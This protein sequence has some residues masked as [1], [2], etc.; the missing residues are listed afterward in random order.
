MEQKG[1]IVR[2][3]EVEGQ[4]LSPYFLVR[5]PDGKD[6]FILNLKILNQFMVKNHFKLE[7]LSTVEQ[8]LCQNDFVASI[9]MKDAYLLIP[10]H[11]ESRKFVRFKFKNQIFEFVSLAFGLSPAPHTY[12]KL[13]KVPISYLRSLGFTNVYYL[14]D[15]LA[16]ERTKEK[17]VENIMTAV[18][19]LQS[20]GFIIN[21]KKSH[22]NPTQSTIFLGIE[23]D[24]KNYCFKLPTEK[25]EHLISLVKH[26]LT[27][28]RCTIRT[29][30]F[31]IGKLISCCTAIEYAYLYTKRMEKDKIFHLMINNN[32]YEANMPISKVVREDLEWW[33]KNLESRVRYIKDY[34]F[35]KTIYTDAS[36]TGWGAT[37]GVRKIHGFWS[38]KEKQAHINFLEL[39]T[40]K[41]ALSELIKNAK[42]IKVLLRIDN[43]TAIFYV[44]KMGGVRVDR[45][46]NLAREIWQWAENREIRL[47]ASYISSKENCIADELSRISQIDIEWELND[48]CFKVLLEKW[49]EPEIDLFASQENKKCRQFVSWKPQQGALCIDA[50]TISW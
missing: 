37:D 19:L 50:F 3:S 26:F 27:L 38:E 16:I 23:I 21:Y 35:D 34:T 20:L 33:S 1:A 32:N 28:E 13:M 24:T 42:N 47:F 36:L 48:R 12:T 17:C 40:V 5:K 8:L 31:L 39:L 25:R 6:R 15:Y 18:K 4:I 29:F 9:D 45:L 46:S 22:I 7:N 10:L 30:A 44:N 49:G 41:I 43:T 14:D 11:V 2:C